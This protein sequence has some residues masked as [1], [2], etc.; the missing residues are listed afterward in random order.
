MSGVATRGGWERGWEGGL[1]RAG[2]RWIVGVKG[3]AAIEELL[4]GL[5]DLPE[6]GRIHCNNWWAPATPS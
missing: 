6:G 5:G 3:G 4:A 2:G 1:D